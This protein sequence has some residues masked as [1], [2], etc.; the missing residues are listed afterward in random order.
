MTNLHS[1]GACSYFQVSTLTVD[2]NIRTCIVVYAHTCSTHTS[3]LGAGGL[4]KNTASLV[5][6]SDTRLARETTENR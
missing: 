6:Q 4:E 1:V 5:H 2:Y 3:S